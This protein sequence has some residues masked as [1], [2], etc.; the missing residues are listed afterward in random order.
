MNLQVDPQGRIFT[1]KEE[2]LSKE[3]AKYT[4]DTY[5]KNG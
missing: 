2:I 5:S 4:L 1:V 3:A